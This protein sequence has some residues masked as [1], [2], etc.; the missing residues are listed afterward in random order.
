MAKRIALLML[1]LGLVVLNFGCASFSGL[2]LDLKITS[3]PSLTLLAN[4]QARPQSGSVT[5][6]QAP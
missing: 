5:N 1:G 4:L 2:V 3:G 6:S